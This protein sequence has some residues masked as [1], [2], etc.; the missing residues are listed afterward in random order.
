MLPP[1]RAWLD[2]QAEERDHSDI[3]V[4]DFPVPSVKARERIRNVKKPGGFAPDL[5]DRLAIGSLRSERRLPKWPGPSTQRAETRARRIY[6]RAPS[7]RYELGQRHCVHW[8][9]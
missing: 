8:S 1:K 9:A 6:P 7:A 2:D 5:S 4:L 3:R